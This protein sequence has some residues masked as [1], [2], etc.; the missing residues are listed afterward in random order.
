MKRKH[1]GVVKMH[2]GSRWQREIV[3]IRLES[4]RLN[5]LQLGVSGLV[6]KSIVAIDGPRVRFAAD[7]IKTNF[8]FET[9]FVASISSAGQLAA[10]GDGT[11]HIEADGMNLNVQLVIVI[12]CFRTT[13]TI[14]LLYPRPRYELLPSGPLH[15]LVFIYATYNRGGAD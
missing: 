7:A 14:M 4:A 3:H 8:C 6:V 9:F 2:G 10:G 13:L 1:W 15:D 12:F 5:I 11:L